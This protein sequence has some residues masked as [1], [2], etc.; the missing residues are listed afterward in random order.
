MNKSLLIVICDFLVSAMLSMMTAVSPGTGGNIG[1]QLDKQTT[2]TI[3]G[4]LRARRDALAERREQLLAAQNNGGDMTESQRAELHELTGELADLMVKSGNLEEQMRLTPRNAKQLSAEELREQLNNE[5][6]SRLISDMRNEELSRRSDKLETE[7][8]EVSA[9]YAATRQQLSAAEKDLLEKSAQLETAGRQLDTTGKELGTTRENLA[10]SQAELR[11]VQENL[12]RELKKLEEARRRTGA[13]ESDLAYAKGKLNTSDRELADAV[14]KFNREQKLRFAAEVQRDEALRQSKAA[15]EMVK[16]VV[17]ER[18][19]LYGKLKSVEDERDRLV[20]KLGIAEKDSVEA[21]GRAE[22]ANAR[23][24]VAQTQLDAAEAK[25]RNDLLKRYSASVVRLSLDIAEDGIVRNRT[26]SRQSYLPVIR[27]G[28][29]EALLG[30]RDNIF[31]GDAGRTGFTKVIRLDYRLTMPDGNGG[32]TALSQPITIVPGEPRLEAFVFN[33][34]NGREPLEVI[35]SDTLRQRGLENLFLFKTGSFGK[36][37]APLDDRCS[38][39]LS[40]EIPALYIRNSRASG[41]ELKAEPGDFVM[42]KQGDFVGV[43]V[44]SESNGITGRKQQAKCYLFRPG[45]TWNGAGQIGITRPE[46]A[47]YYQEFGDKVR[48]LSTAK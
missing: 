35:D 45:F 48:D 38:L 4:E 29:R 1:V 33:K 7:F 22:A 28:G 19:A 3:L 15:E 31:G 14:G 32:D 36:E 11:L 8:R 27:L 23:L 43:V 37:S 18:S 47:Q 24:E 16:N 46:G 20:A 13:L 9:S 26:L 40:G 5:L 34:V 42:T 10:A 41:S 21:K 25:L 44:E 39:D 30:Y 12:T 17:S 6:R 2:E